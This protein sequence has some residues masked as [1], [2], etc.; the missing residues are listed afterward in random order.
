MTDRPTVGRSPAMEPWTVAFAGPGC[1]SP[2]HTS[3]VVPTSRI[4]FPPRRSFW[5]SS[6][7]CCYE[8]T[9][10]CLA[11]QRITFPSPFAELWTSARVCF[12][13][14]SRGVCLVRSKQASACSVVLCWLVLRDSTRHF[15]HSSAPSTY[16]SLASRDG[17][18]V[19]MRVQCLMIAA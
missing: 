7:C 4:G 11:T 15:V 14:S 2:Q 1:L 5:F 16:V 6:G 10:S 12:L 3:L 18:V 8:T 17:W 19:S 9:E 13:I